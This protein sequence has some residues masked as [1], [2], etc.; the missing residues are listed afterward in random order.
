[1]D[2]YTQA[3]HARIYRE[4]AERRREVQ[5]V[6]L[7]TGEGPRQRA[8]CDNDGNHPGG[9]VCRDITPMGSN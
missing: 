2:I 3:Q 4:F 5:H 6:T 8:M 1:M 9:Y 7:W